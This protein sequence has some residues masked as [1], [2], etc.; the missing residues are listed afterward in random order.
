MEDEPGVGLRAEVHH[1]RPRRVQ[2]ALRLRDVVP[3]HQ[4]LRRGPLERL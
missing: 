4:L 3:G 1:E 2:H